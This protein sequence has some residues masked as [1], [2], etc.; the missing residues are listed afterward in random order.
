MNLPKIATFII[1]AILG[2]SALIAYAYHTQ[3]LVYAKDLPPNIVCIKDEIPDAYL[4]V[5]EE[6]IP[7]YLRLRDNLTETHR[8][9]HNY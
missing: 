8:Q 5:I 6:D 2:Y 7:W 9:I 3:E 4:C 1:C